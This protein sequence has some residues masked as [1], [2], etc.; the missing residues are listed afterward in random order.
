MADTTDVELAGHLHGL[1]EGLEADGYSLHV[2]WVDT[3]VEIAIQ[4]G[5]EACEDCLVPKNVMRGMAFTA[6]TDA[7]IPIS[8]DQIEVR[9]PASS[10]A[11]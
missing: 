10:K 2:R 6:L 8:Q 5:S 3:T 7:G 1:S 11:N 9:Y 4:A